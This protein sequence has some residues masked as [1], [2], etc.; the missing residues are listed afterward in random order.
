MYKVSVPIM[1]ATLKRADRGKVAEQLK[2][3]DASRVF[4]ALPTYTQD[5]EKRE[6][7]LAE[8]EDNCSFFKS[9]GY[10]VGAWNWALTMPESNSFTKMKDLSGN[11]TEH[12]LCPLDEK[13]LRFSGEYFADIART[14]VQMI[15]FDDDFRFGLLSKFNQ[16][17]C[18]CEHHLKLIC[19]IL[20][21]TLTTEELIKKIYTGGRNKYRDAWLEANKMSLEGMARNIRKA[22]DAVNPDIAIGVCSCTSSWDIDGGTEN[23]DTVLSPN[24]KAFRRLIGAPYWATTDLPNC[25]IQNVVELERMERSWICGGAEIFA[26][27][28]TWPR[29]RNICPSGYLEIFDTALRADGSFDG[30]LKYGLDYVSTAG[31]ELGYADAHE[32]NRELYAAIEKHFGGKTACGVRVY[33]FQKKVAD[34]ELDES[35]MKTGVLDN[36]FFSPAAKILTDNSVPTVYDGGGLCGIAFG[37]NAWQIGD[38]EMKNGLILDLRAAKILKKRGIDVGIEEIG[39]AAD[40]TCEHFL[41][42]NEWI[43]ISASAHELKLK[44][45]AEVIS[46]F[47]NDFDC[48]EG[49]LPAVYLYR[50]DNGQKFAV[51]NFDSRR[52]GVRNNSGLFRSYARSR[53]L[54]GICRWLSGSKLSAHTSGNPDIYVMTKKSEDDMAVGLWNCFADAAYDVEVTLE[55]AFNN[56]EFIGCEGRLCGDK[57]YIDKIPPFEFAGFVVKP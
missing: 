19:E 27:G 16:P 55:H 23:I 30:I 47:Y 25:R 33:E 8:L 49:E 26:E 3:F 51:Y 43:I 18:I 37:D 41:K 13:F 38:D 54:A 36:S 11:S 42:Q 17:C 34:M 22:V 40:K 7:M 46:K 35:D 12:Y 6:K 21:E 45:G 15:M 57:V 44:D 28:D 31:Y 10:E 50:N 2:R 29:P 24:T 56:I 4:L 20:G 32:R 39:A 1:N 53:Q 14:G 52:E 5:K 48:T 9:L